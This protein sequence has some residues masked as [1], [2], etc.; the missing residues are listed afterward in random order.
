MYVSAVRARVKPNV[1]LVVLDSV[2][3]GNTSLYGHEHETTPFLESFAET[4]VVYDQARS[5]GT[6]SLP[7]HTSMFT[8]YDVVEHGLTR[9]EYAIEPGHTVFERLA[10]E[11]GYRTGVFSENT[12]ITDM[13]VGL[14]DAFDTVEG[15]RNL[16]YPGA[17]DPS[18]FV[19]SEGQGQ[20]VAYLRRCL[21]DDRPVQS[22]A[23]G[24]VTK[25][26]WDFP[27]YLPDALSA[28]TPASVY[29]DLFL[30][31]AAETD[32]SWAACVNFMDAHL[33]YEP[34]TAH[35]RWG[36]DR[37]RDLQ[38]GM[39]DQVWEFNG[40]RRPWWQRRALEGLYDG[41]IHQMDAQLRRLIETLSERE[42]LDD[43]LVVVT[44]DHGEG[45]G[46]PS[47]VRPGARVAAHGAGIHE[48]LLHV[49]LVVRPPG[50]ADGRRVASPASLTQ[51]PT[52]VDRSLDD[53]WTPETFC[54]DGPVVASSHGLE[55]PMEERA[56]RYCEDL[57][58][59]NGD[60][61]AVYHEDG[62]AVRKDVT[63]R[64]EAATVRCWD[65]KTSRATET[66]DAAAR[67]A[68]AF[69]D[70]SSRSVRLSET[71]SVDRATQRRLEELGYA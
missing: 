21:T 53:E 47:R 50:G 9:A 66:D 1:L 46:E 15:A 28:S 59:F 30:D 36:G 70:R 42:V 25:L 4:G 20:Y 17:I 11:E 65:A 58:R 31:W 22:L 43:T 37:L 18:N 8:G 3:A 61:R 24:V 64:S 69:E 5:P 23:N 34:A 13:A 29:T 14:K 54:P 56:S 38:D 12:W 52:A 2:R 41:T 27:R 16:P 39:G 6:W 32:G 19:L 67:V 57:W 51:F 68:T 35:D 40:D 33:P 71:G 63:W 10:D 55:E 48:A 62:D 44:S 26:A 49:P 60:A 45:F 7:S